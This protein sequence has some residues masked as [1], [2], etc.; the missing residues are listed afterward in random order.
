MYACVGRCEMMLMVLRSR[1][2]A[3]TLVQCDDDGG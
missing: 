2:L 3:P 1:G